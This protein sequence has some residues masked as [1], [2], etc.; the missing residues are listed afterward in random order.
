MLMYRVPREAYKKLELDALLL[1]SGKNEL[2]LFCLRELLENIRLFKIY[3]ATD[4]RV[5][6]SSALTRSI[7]SVTALEMGVDRSAD[8]APSLL[9]IYGA[10]KSEFLNSIREARLKSIEAIERDFSEILYALE[11]ASRENKAA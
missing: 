6:R 7:M 5:A 3:D 4:N 1:G 2:T 10:A 9:Q 11:A 8:L